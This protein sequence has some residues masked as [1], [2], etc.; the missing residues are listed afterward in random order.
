MARAI[1]RYSCNSK[2]AGKH[3]AE[4]ARK[5]LRDILEAKHFCKVGAAAKGTAAWEL[6]GVSTPTVAT[7]LREVMEAVSA[8]PTGVLDHVWIYC[9]E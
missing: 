1:I 5:A 8:F 7:A 3:Q 2:P 4:K 6:S 9:D